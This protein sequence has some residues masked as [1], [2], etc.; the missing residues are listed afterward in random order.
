[1]QGQLQRHM[2]KSRGQSDKL[3]SYQ[4]GDEAKSE[5]A[6]AQLRENIP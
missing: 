5:Q 4:Y 1:M 6:L 2:S 3:D